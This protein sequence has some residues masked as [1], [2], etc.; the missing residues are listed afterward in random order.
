MVLTGP[1]SSCVY[2]SELCWIDFYCVQG[3]EFG[4]IIHNNIFAIFGDW[5]VEKIL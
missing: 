3:D 5:N 2:F 1:I 4:I